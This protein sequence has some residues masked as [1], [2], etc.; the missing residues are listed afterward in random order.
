VTLPPVRLRPV[1]PDEADVLEAG[2]TGDPASFNWTGHREPGWLRLRIDERTM[3]RDDG[4][5]LG[6]FDENGA[7]L[8]DVGWRR[9]DS[10]P[11]PYS[12]C[13]NLGIQLLPA[14]RGRGLGGAAQRAAAEYL[15]AHTPCARVEADT[16][17]DN[18]SEHRALEKAGFT[19]EGVTR[20]TH[21][22]A[23]T[24]HDSV[25]YAVVRGDW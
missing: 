8:G 20:S 9:R 14:H 18:I 6:V 21:F 10:G 16:D 7:L 23:G 5:L 1:T 24:W 17:V 2:Y 13:W 12:W 4:G 3:L 25:L 19:R 22:R 15:F 11:P